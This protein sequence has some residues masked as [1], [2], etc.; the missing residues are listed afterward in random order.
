MEPDKS[1]KVPWRRVEI[2]VSRFMKTAQIDVERL[3]QLKKNIVEVSK[4]KP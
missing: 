2:A 3:G 4:R 1:T